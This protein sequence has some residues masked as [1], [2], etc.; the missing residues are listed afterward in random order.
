MT[1]IGNQHS[2]SLLWIDSPSL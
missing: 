2:L 1:S